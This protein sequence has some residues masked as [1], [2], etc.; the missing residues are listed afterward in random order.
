MLIKSRS[1]ED[2]IKNLSYVQEIATIDSQLKST[3]SITENISIIFLL[4]KIAAI[5]LGVVILYNLGILSYTERTREY[6][7]LKVLGFYQKEIRSFA[8][9]ENVA[10]TIVGWLVG[11][12]IGLSFLGLYVK[13]VSMDSFDWVPKITP[14]SFIIASVITVGCSIG[15]SLLLSQK[16]KSINMV[17][18]LKSVE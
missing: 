3:Q 8:L 5:L 2:K 6:A 12:P 17:E 13:T 4:L 10:I 7:T 15:V 1:I 14:L 18:A 16:V 9:R 11:I